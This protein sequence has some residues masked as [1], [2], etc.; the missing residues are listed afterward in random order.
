MAEAF[1]LARE[2]AGKSMPAKIAMIAMTTRS[3]I[4]VNPRELR[5]I[6][7]GLNTFSS[8]RGKRQ[9]FGEDLRRKKSLALTD[10]LRERDGF[11]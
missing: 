8:V 7:I 1:S 11:V 2:S 6:V 5:R 10:F 9:E 3:S 4:K